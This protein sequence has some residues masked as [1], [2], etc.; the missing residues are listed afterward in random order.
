MIAFLG[1]ISFLA[2]VVSAILWI[3]NRKDPIKKGLWR[4][5]TTVSFVL[6]VILLI[7]DGP[8]SPSDVAQNTQKKTEDNQVATTSVDPNEEYKQKIGVLLNEL[9]DE[10]QEQKAAYDEAKWAAFLREYRAKHKVESD[11]MT[12][13]SVAVK[14]AMSDLLTLANELTNDLQGRNA[15]IDFFKNSIQETISK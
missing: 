4:N 3:V 8:S 9:L 7:V 6:F 13:A 11:K 10:Y 2:S 15:D 1:V 12:E 14:T 5:I